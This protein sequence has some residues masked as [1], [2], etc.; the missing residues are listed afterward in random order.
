MK[1]WTKGQGQE[2]SLTPTESSSTECNLA[3][4]P[5]LGTLVGQGGKPEQREEQASW[6]QALQVLAGRWKMLGVREPLQ[7]PDQEKKKKIK[8]D[9]L[10]S[11]SLT[12]GLDS[13]WAGGGES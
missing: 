10:T 4:A 5:I 8:Q 2:R 7:A 9:L 13:Y 3:K 12:L 6:Q 1:E 11:V